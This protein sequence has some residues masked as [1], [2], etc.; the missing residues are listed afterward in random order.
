M[1]TATDSQL[2]NT[3]VK[4]TEE[5]VLIMEEMMR[6]TILLTIA[7]MLLATSGVFAIPW[8]QNFNTGVSD[9]T[10]YDQ[11]QITWLSGDKFAGIGF[12]YGNA[13]WDVYDSATLF[14]ATSQSG[15]VTS[16]PNLAMNFD[17]TTNATSFVWQQFNGSAMVAEIT[18][19]N[20]YSGNSAHSWTYFPRN[21]PQSTGVGNNRLP[22]P[23]TPAAVPEAS[24]L[25]G[26]GSAMAMAGPGMIGWLRRRRA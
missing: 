7:L 6:K 26:F 22:N 20:V 10:G 3:Q 2:Q 19:N 24:T 23:S 5:V 17:G 25:I 11:L 15:A 14:I 8:L 21:D 13:G 9:P 16:G 12:W 1:N 18:G 4:M